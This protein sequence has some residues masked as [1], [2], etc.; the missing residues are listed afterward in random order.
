MKGRDIVSG[1]FWVAVSIFACLE[2]LS[3]GVGS[4]SRPGSGFLPFWSAVVIG[5]FGAILILKSCLRKTPVEKKLPLWKG[6][7]WGK[8]IVVLAT[9]SV[10][11]I[12]LT[13]IGYLIATFL[14]MVVLF[15][16]VE[17]PRV[18]T[19]V[20]TALITVVATYLVFYVWL[21]IQLPKGIL[22]F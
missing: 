9:L 14:L 19:Q 21:D 16:I 13:R 22:D 20:L 8:V 5:G 2:A 7:R 18:W 4:F 12:F 10:Y 6:L 17:R 3:V 1:L 11:T 15:G